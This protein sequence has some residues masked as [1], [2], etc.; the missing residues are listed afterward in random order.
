[1]IN[2]FTNVKPTFVGHSFTWFTQPLPD[3]ALNKLCL[4]VYHEC[5]LIKICYIFRL[6]IKAAEL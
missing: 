3:D 2:K 4:Y 5:E 1:M 6:D